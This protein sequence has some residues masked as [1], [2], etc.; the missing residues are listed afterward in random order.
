MS[1]FRRIFNFEKSKVEQLEK[2]L[3]QRYS[4]GSGF[5]LQATVR[6]GGRDYSARIHDMSVNGVRAQVQSGAA[7]AAGH[8]VQLLLMLGQHRLEIEARIAHQQARD[9]G[10]YL[11]L[12]LVFP[13][14]E[15]QK[16]YLQLLQPVVIGQS[17]RP[18]P[19]ETVVQ[20][21]PRF[22]KQTY[23]GESDS[24]LTVRLDQARGMALQGFDFRMQNY[25]CRGDLQSDKTEAGA[26]ESSDSSLT[27]P[28]FETSGGLHDEIHQLFRWVVPNLG[29]AV[30]E[31]VRAFLQRFAA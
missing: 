9:G 11:G 13:E 17:L 20:D 5:P 2:R 8:H 27:N 28:V 24:Q 21:D 15:L 30:P 19:A 14:F 12:G 22:H 31:D 1:I 6:A 26:L 10:Q 3:N 25:F 18:M 23:T 4:I 7:L 16:T 29:N